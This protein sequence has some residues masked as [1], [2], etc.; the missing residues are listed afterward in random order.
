MDVLQFNKIDCR[1]VASDEDS[2]PESISDTQN[3][4]N[5]DGDLDNLNDSEDDSKADVESDIELYNGIKD[6]ESPEQQDENA[7]PHIPGLIQPTRKSKGKAEQVLVMVNA[8]EM[9][10]NKRNKKM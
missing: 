3:W 10:S 9:R 5:W 6:S 7:A 8:L 4:Q 1:L 2:P